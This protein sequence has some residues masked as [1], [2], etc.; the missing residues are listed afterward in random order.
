M[1]GERGGTETVPMRE[2]ASRKFGEDAGFDKKF[3][4]GTGIQRQRFLERILTVVETILYSFTDKILFP[5]KT[6]APF[7]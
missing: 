7:L 6:V 4:R 3:L 1:A 2:T 5:S